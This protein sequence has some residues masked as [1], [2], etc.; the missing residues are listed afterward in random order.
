MNS[1]V[2][3][4]H[5]FEENQTKKLKGSFQTEFYPFLKLKWLNFSY[6][7]GIWGKNIKAFISYFQREFSSDMTIAGKYKVGEVIYYLVGQPLLYVHFSNLTN[8]KLVS[9]W[10][11]VSSNCLSR[12]LTYWISCQ[13]NTKTSIQLIKQH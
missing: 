13:K 4:D 2:S 8:R 12:S 9:S 1:L 7:R 3:F 10:S 5:F 6:R 11:F